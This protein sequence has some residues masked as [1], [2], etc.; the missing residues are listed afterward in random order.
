MPENRLSSFRLAAFVSP[1]APFSAFLM[2]VIVF[3][4]PFYAGTVG[5][6]LSAVGL[7]FGLTKLWDMVTDPAF[8]ILSDRWQLKWGRRLP[9]LVASVPILGL[10][11]Y[12]TF[13]PGSSVGPGYFAFW[14]VFLYVGWTIG[15]VSHMAWA[16][17]LSTE[18]HERSRISAYKQAAALIGSLGL[19]LLVA[20][21][22]GVRG[23]DETSRMQLIATILLVLLPVCVAAALWAT[24][25]RLPSE[26]I[27]NNPSNTWRIIWRNHPL[28]LLL[29]SNLLLGIAAGGSAGMILFYVEEVL[30]L[31]SWSSF[32]LVPFLFSGLLFLPGFVI[33]GRR[34][35]KHRTLCYALIYQIG[36]SLLYLV[37]PA[38]SVLLAS[39]AFLLLGANQAVGTYIPRAIM[40]DV[41]DIDTAESGVQQTGLY[42]ALLQSTSKVAAALAIGLSYP[43]LG[44][45]GFDPAPDTA[46]SDSTLFGLRMMMVL[47]PGAAFVLIILMMWNFPLN[48]TSHGTLRKKISALSG[49]HSE[50]GA[51]GV[52]A[53]ASASSSVSGQ[54]QS[55]DRSPS[56]P[57]AKTSEADRIE[58]QKIE[59]QLMG[60]QKL[61][62][63]GK[64]KDTGEK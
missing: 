25:E 17:E 18:Y 15:S 11:T 21:Y 14:M 6:G 10:C 16:A 24:P 8:G 53:L 36:A 9:W 59:G 61:T 58:P 2:A 22:D 48:E 57:L 20:Y 31:G 19:I 55:T 54:T 60:Q 27:E 51:V 49:R 43:V 50:D 37:I 44:L 3:V 32:A 1:E 62:I 40:A 38:G 23:L 41:T 35:G 7:I 56:A 29:A 46:N 13:V 47:F 45:I 33:L 63:A 26:E 12:M 42:M 4:P 34:I 30:Q 5:L 28:R 39:L 52:M 64:P